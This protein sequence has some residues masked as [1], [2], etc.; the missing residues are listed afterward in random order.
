MTTY[1]RLIALTALATASIISSAQTPEPA[2]LSGEIDE[3]VV[4]GTR[5]AADPRHLS[6]TV[7][8]IGQEQIENSLTPSLLPTVEQQV[9]G[10]FVTKRGVLGYGVSTGAAGSIAIRGL[11]GGAGRMMVLIDGHP[12]YSGIFGHPISD[13]YQSMIAERVEVLRGPASVLYG[14]NAMGGVLNIVTRQMNTDGIRNHA[15]I[16]FG[17]YNTLN[18]GFTNRMRFGR[19]NSVAAISYD[20]TAG[21]RDN[22][23]FDQLSGLLK[24]GYRLSNHFDLMADVDVTHFNAS[25]PGPVTAPLVDARQHITRGMANA[26]LND[27]FD[28]ASG[29][30]SVF[31]NWGHHNINDG[32]K[33]DGGS[34]RPYR[35]KS[36]DDLLGI[37]AYQTLTFIESNRITAGFDW[38]R[39]GG[40]AWNRYITGEKEGTSDILVD[41]AQH[42]V[43][44]YLDVR[45]E[46]TR[47]V[48]AN[49]GLRIDH[50]SL[51]GTQWIPQ[52]GVATHLPYS[53][54]LKLS[55]TKGFRNP[56]FREQF[57]WGTA[58]PDLRPESLWNYELALSQRLLSNRLT[59]G[60]NVFHINAKNII[61]PTMIDGRS[62]NANSGRLKNT[63]L[64]LAAAFR[65]N[66]L[67][68]VEANYSYVHTDKVIAGAPKHKLYVA[69]TF[70]KGNL[71]LSTGVE[72]INGLPTSD[73]AD[74]AIENFVLWNAQ[75]AY[76]FLPWLKA[77]G[78]VDNI[79]AQR[80]EINAGFPMPTA[81]A[82]LGITF[83]F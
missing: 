12:Q 47:Y 38:Y 26:A 34:P 40:K 7:T 1:Y 67:W 31:Y 17:S 3:V 5:S 6:Q 73:S 15:R 11:S 30:L 24:L 44:G 60:V 35:F 39:I 78:K 23:K 41:K 57:L 83:D 33:I 2:E 13:A 61:V 56:T 80:Y 59:W 81:T 64:E 72:Y 77:W 53:L 58:N 82:M 22:T 70:T 18:A 45:Q 69:G 79:L 10:V 52:V 48:T 50:H 74:A 76:R 71:S 51:T 9:P 14:S 21:H 27:H 29:Q 62:V 20:R 16:A 42:E 19:F 36:D 66:S 46:I 43:A 8:V 65:I 63:G 25:N 49:A 68:N 75:A 4:T 55:A 37:S 32:Y 54:E 28:I